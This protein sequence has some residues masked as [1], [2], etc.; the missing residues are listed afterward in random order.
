MTG[1]VW[2]RWYVMA[3]VDSSMDMAEDERMPP[4]S[5]SV[6]MVDD[7]E[8]GESRPFQ[9]TGSSR[10]FSFQR[11][12]NA[13]DG[14]QRKGRNRNTPTQPSLNPLQE[15]QVKSELHPRVVQT[16]ESDYVADGSD[17]NSLLSPAS[18]SP[19]HDQHAVL[20]DISN[21]D[22]SNVSSRVAPVTDLAIN[23][24]DEYT[25]SCV[26][27]TSSV[28]DYQKCSDS[29][30]SSTLGIKNQN[31][32]ETC[33]L[34]AH[35]ASLMSP[36]VNDG[37]HNQTYHSRFVTTSSHCI[38]TQ[39]NE[40]LQDTLLVTTNNNSNDT[41]DNPTHVIQTAQESDGLTTTNTEG[42]SCLLLNHHDFTTIE[43]D[44]C[45]VNCVQ[46]I[47]NLTDENNACQINKTT[48]CK[49]DC[50]LEYRVQKSLVSEDAPH[51]KPSLYHNYDSPHTSSHT[52]VDSDG[53]NENVPF[54]GDV[55]SASYKPVNS[56][57]VSF[58]DQ[59]DTWFVYPPEDTTN[60][61]DCSELSAKH[62]N[63]WNTNT[64]SLNPTGKRWVFNV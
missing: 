22:A 15:K 29:S 36:N 19:Q 26:N 48:T 49:K 28:N 6:I 52:N 40:S 31:D 54:P 58:G 23:T 13:K 50:V 61:L 41:N 60:D 30:S 35:S 39:S 57:Q 53:Q 8:L 47:V 17:G 44:S 24:Y 46:D 33:V 34:E 2:W 21:L 56:K 1:H 45:L 10:H 14:R 43:Y 3:R 7:E 27:N 32:S 12:K 59:A 37:Y 20:S 16:E 4:L 51:Q 9:R 11:K 18:T 38:S 42:S 5:P 25:N 63:D 55:Y 64:P 62:K